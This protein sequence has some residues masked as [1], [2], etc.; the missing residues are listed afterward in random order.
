MQGVCLVHPPSRAAVVDAG[1]V[2][3][4]LARLLEAPGAVL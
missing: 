3:T 2:E 1:G 4:L